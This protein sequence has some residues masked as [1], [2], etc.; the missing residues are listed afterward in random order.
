MD[1]KKKAKL[2]TRWTCYSCL[3]AFYDLNKPEPIC[4]RCNAD[5]RDT[6]KVEPVKPKRK[7][8]AAKKKPTINKKLAEEEEV[9]VR[10]N[11]ETSEINLDSAGSQSADELQPEVESD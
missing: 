4:P 7:R 2:G 11:D 5:Q 1:A 3:G 6:P 10:S 9:V 8:K